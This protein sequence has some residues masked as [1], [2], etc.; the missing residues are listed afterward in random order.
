MFHS[1]LIASQV[2]EHLGLS[3]KNAQQLSEITD[4][5]P[6]QPQWK[7]DEFHVAGEAFELY[8]RNII[9]CVRA[10]YG[11]PKFANQMVFAPERHFSKKGQN[12]FR[13]YHEMHTGQWW[14]ETQDAVEK[15]TP[16][17]TIIPIILSSDKTQITLFRNKAAYPVYMTIGNIPKSIWRKPS[18]HAYILVAYLPTSQLQHITNKAARR[19]TLANVFH[20]CMGRITEPLKVAG[21]SGLNMVS[22]DGT[23]HHTHPILATF[24]GDYPEQALVTG[25]KTGDCPKCPVTHEELGDNMNPGLKDLAKILDALA[26]FDEQSPADWNKQ[27]KDAGI[28]PIPK[29]FWVGLPY[30]HIFR[31]ISSDVLHQLY[32]GII[33]HILSWVKSVFST[34]EID[35]RCRRFPPNHH[36]RIFMQGITML[37]RISGK[38]HNKICH[39]LLGLIIG[40][41]LPGNRS[42]YQLVCA[43]R[44]ILDF[45]YLAQYPVHTTKT[46]ELMKDALDCFH[47]NKVIFVDLGIRSNFNI[48]K[49]H[50]LLHY[51]ESIR[52][53]GTTDNYNTEYTERL[54]IDF[55]KD[56]YAATNHKDEYVQM[57]RWLERKEKMHQFQNF[58]A[59]RTDPRSLA[60]FGNEQKLPQL[61]PERELKMPKHPTQRAVSIETLITQ[62]GATYFREALAR[63][64]AITL[65]P[66]LS[67]NQIEQRATGIFLPTSTV[68]VFHTLKFIDAQS[69]AT[70]DAAHAKPARKDRWQRPIPGRFDTVL[71]K[72]GQQ[73]ETR[74]KGETSSTGQKA[75]K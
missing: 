14:W 16:G 2:Q 66:E 75:I 74:V 28:K 9:E 69:G 7:R 47:D 72:V 65:H 67:A 40:M 44:S 58:I 61:L 10:L 43:V 39:I 60:S 64:V 19:R 35:A 49:L 1:H 53:F 23:V 57:T 45:L 8:H 13:I 4:S 59:W 27:C 18:Q 30:T 24:V 25:T 3:Y 50:A 41:H 12:T 11:D 42:P 34:T 51:S 17:A 33:K 36:I 48:P 56:A 68:P 32:Q 6:T 21:A 37:S 63:F 5:L 62:Y 71:V 54:H 70:L 52:L 73:S 55:A 46:L 38:E 26:T 20:A 29:P 15:N 22:G 31:S